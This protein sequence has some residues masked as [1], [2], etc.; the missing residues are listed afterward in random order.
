MIRSGEIGTDLPFAEFC[1]DVR[2]ALALDLR[3]YK[4]EFLQPRIDRRRAALGLGSLRAYRDRLLADE[5]EQRRLRD[6]VTAGVSSFYRDPPLFDALAR[7]HLPALRAR[8]GGSIRVWCAGVGAGQELYSV[9]CL[10]ADAGWLDRADLLGTDVNATAIAK[11]EA[12]I[13]DAVDLEAAPR[14]WPRAYFRQVPLGLSV[15][16]EIRARAGFCYGDVLRTPPQPDFDLILCRNVAIYLAPSVQRTLYAGLAASL[17]PG[18]ILFV[19]S[20]ERPADPDRLGLRRLAPSFYERLPD[21]LP[22]ETAP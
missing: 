3:A 22:V 12:G 17:R 19:G 15:R 13:Y 21:P 7:I 16:E 2:S 6:G 1:R 8:R 11:A 18:G 5:R 20:S 10:L 9:A 4:P 14:H